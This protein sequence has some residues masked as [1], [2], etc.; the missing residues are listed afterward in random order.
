MFNTTDTQQ[1]KKS[2]CQ[3]RVSCVGM[4]NTTGI[5]SSN[6]IYLSVECQLNVINSK[7][8]TYLVTIVNLSAWTIVTKKVNYFLLHKDNTFN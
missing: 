8:S 1:L 2:T 5:H 6:K 3:L 7:N 4:F